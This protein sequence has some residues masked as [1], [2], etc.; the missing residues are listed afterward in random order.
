MSASL[1]L[2]IVMAV[3]YAAGIYIMLERS[4]TRVLIGFLLVGNATNLLIFIMSGRPGSSPIV[5]GTA[6]DETIVD[7]LPQV[8][9]LTAIVINFGM[10]ALL[11]ALI[12]RSWWL[13]QLGD[14]GDTLTDEHAAETSADSEVTFRSSSDDEAAV[15][16]SLDAS[17]DGSDDDS[18]STGSSDQEAGTR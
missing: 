6:L 7:P 13:A 14:E 5:T 2:V 4:L 11:L 15:Q 18:G 1:T 10:T 17:E 16:A 3:M 8:L 9:M 12:Y